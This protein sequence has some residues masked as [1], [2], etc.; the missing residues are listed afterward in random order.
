MASFPTSVKTFTTL[1]DNVDSILAAHQNERGDE[2]TAIETWLLAGGMTNSNIT[3]T[4]AD[5]TAAVNTRYFADISGLTANRNF[6]LPTPAIGNVIEIN[7]TVG[8][9]AYALIIKGNTGIK[10]NK[11]STATEWSRLFI[12]GETVRFVADATDNWQVVRDGRIP[13]TTRIKN[14]GAQSIS[15]GVTTVLTLDELEYDNASCANTT[16]NRIDVRRANKYV[17]TGGVQLDSLAANTQRV[18]GAITKNVTPTYIVTAEISGD[19]GAYVSLLPV[20]TDALAVGDYI[21]LRIFHN[22]GS[23]ED[24]YVTIAPTHLEFTEV[25]T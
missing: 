22:S 18:F 6:I 3:P 15:N 21:Q 23:S 1:T 7:I 11:G 25:L 13:C 10:I 24:T 4:T 8:D 2:I 12:S 17:M 20:T 14:T 5:T 19:S 16:N 9:S